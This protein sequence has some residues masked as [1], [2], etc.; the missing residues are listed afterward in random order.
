MVALIEFLSLAALDLVEALAGEPG[1]VLGR[2]GMLERLLHALRA[3]T[4][5]A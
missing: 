5:E 1:L 2:P 4:R 3:A